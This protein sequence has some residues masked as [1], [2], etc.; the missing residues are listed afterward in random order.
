[1]EIHP[2]LVLLIAVAIVFLLILRLKINAFIA[3]VTAATR[4]VYRIQVSPLPV[5][6]ELW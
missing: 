3:L 1:M 2:L 4:Q 5:D 6:E